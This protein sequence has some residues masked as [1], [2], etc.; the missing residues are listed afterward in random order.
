MNRHPLITEF[1]EVIMNYSRTK[2]LNNLQYLVE[3]KKTIS[4]SIAKGKKGIR[5]VELPRPMKILYIN[6]NYAYELLLNSPGNGADL[7]PLKAVIDLLIND[8]GYLGYVNGIRINGNTTRCHVF[9][10]EEMD[11]DIKNNYEFKRIES[12]PKSIDQKKEKDTITKAEL[13]LLKTDAEIQKNKAETH[14]CIDE[15]EISK[16]AELRRILE[17]HHIDADRSVMGSEP[18]FVPIVTGKNRDIVLSKL[19]EIIKEF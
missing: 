8:I 3:E 6:I 2:K 15:I 9:N 10:I 18:F 7:L 19:L 12:N 11:I 16:V 17:T 5:E 14:K 4:L 1:W 13:D